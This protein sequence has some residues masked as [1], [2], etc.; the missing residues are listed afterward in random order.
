MGL[1]PATEELLFERRGEA[2]EIG[3]VTFNRPQAR[4]ALTFAMYE[5]VAE[6]A[7]RADRDPSLRVLVFTG[8]GGRAFAAGTDISQFRA[9]D[10]EQDALQYEERMD[11]V[12]T[13]L[14]TCR[15]PTIAAIQG[16]CTGGGAGI[17]ACCDLRVGSPSARFGFPIARTLGN[18]LSMGNFARL[19]ALLGL[20]RVKDLIFSARLLDAPEALAIGLFNEVTA[21]E[22]SLP[23]RAGDLARTLA[24]HAPLT[25][26][27]AKEAL[28]R[29]KQQ[30]IPP[31]GGSDLVLRA[32]MSEDFRKAPA[33]LEGPL[34]PI[35]SCQVLGLSS[36]GRSPDL[37]ARHPRPGRGPWTC[38]GRPH[39]WRSC[40]GPACG[41]SGPG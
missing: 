41:G 23:L 19:T 28:H 29:I 32:Y 34:E 7:A 22:E 13:V 16:A 18:T 17:A 27:T 12:L 5:G 4:N 36:S 33:G 24:G 35:G 14:E 6:I 9:F 20:A 2:G 3:W 25:L 31:G 37:S 26:Q 40:P 39:S 15:I 21:D 10:S 1:E 30:L 8:A 11:R 38:S